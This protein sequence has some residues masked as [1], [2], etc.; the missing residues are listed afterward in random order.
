MIHHAVKPRTTLRTCDCGHA[1][2]LIEA[3]GRT[4]T[5]PRLLG[6]PARTFHVECCRCGIATRPAHTQADAEARWRSG[7]LF[8]VAASTLTALRAQLERA[9]ANA[10]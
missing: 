1:P 3:R 6:L 9:L 8:L 10:A 2:H 4:I 7:G 5:D